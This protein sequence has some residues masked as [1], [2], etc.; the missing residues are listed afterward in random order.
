VAVDQVVV[1][2][3]AVELV[4]AVPVAVAAVAL[5]VT[6]SCPLVG[7]VELVVLVAWVDPAL[8]AVMAAQAELVAPAVVRLRSWP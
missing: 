2:E 5:T 1:P 3:L 8:T 4:A 6:S 7:M